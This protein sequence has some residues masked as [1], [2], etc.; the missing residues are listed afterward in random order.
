MANGGGPVQRL[1]A[2]LQKEVDATVAAFRLSHP[3]EAPR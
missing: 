3:T 1:N 2:V